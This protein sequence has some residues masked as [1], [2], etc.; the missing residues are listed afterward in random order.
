MQEMGD[1]FYLLMG[2]CISGW[3]TVEEYLFKVC[4]ACLGCSKQQAAIVYYR[5]PTIEA[6]R[7]LADELVKTVLPRKTPPSGGH[8]HE[9]VKVWNAIQKEIEELLP[10]RNRIAHQPMGPHMEFDS[11]AR[12][13]WFEIYMSDHEQARKDQSVAGLRKEDLQAHIMAVW[14]LKDRLAAFYIETVPTY[15]KRPEESGPRRVH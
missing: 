10:T 15:V 1:E 4:W 3:A 9:D 8:D 7:Q 5:T 6:R 12:E 13:L 11:D 14:L 2:N